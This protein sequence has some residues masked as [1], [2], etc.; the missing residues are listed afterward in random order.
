[1]STENCVTA[2]THA[3]GVGKLIGQAQVLQ[4]ADNSHEFTHADSLNPSVDLAGFVTDADG[5][6]VATAI[7]GVFCRGGE[8]F[9]IVGAR[10]FPINQL[11][12]HGVLSGCDVG[13]FAYVLKYLRK[14]LTTAA[15]RA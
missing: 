6:C 5:H 14:A 2:F 4:G 12:V 11:R 13:E 7:A 9:V 8:Y 1:M 10:F 15:G 3:G